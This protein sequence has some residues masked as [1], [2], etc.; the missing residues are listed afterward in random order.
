[1]VVAAGACVAKSQG[2]VAGC[3]NRLDWLSAVREIVAVEQR[4]PDLGYR[5]AAD[6]DHGLWPEQQVMG[7]NA[8][9]SAPSGLQGVS[10]KSF[11]AG[12]DD[13]RDA[14]R[15]PVSLQLQRRPGRLSSAPRR[16]SSCG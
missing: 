16:A 13:S 15:A 8:V 7:G 14:G 4:T 1:M 6:V 3:S 12:G 5:K 11:A 9:E 2:H 10:P